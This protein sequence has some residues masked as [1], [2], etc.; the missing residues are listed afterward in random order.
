MKVTR[1]EWIGWGL[2]AGAVAAAGGWRSAAFAN[3]APTGAPHMTVIPSTGEQLPCVG[4]GTVDYRGGLSS[5][6]MDTLRET[7]A[8][9]HR[10]GGRVLDTSPNYGNS[11]EVLGHLLS[12]I[13]IRDAMWIATKVDQADQAGGERRMQGSFERLG[14]GIE[15]MQ[16]HNLVGA[17]VQLET[18]KAW[19]ADGRF[20]YIGITTHRV[21]QQD[22]IMRYMREHDLDFVQVN[23]SV[24]DRAAADR[25][26]PLAQDRGVAVLVNRPFGD[27][28]LFRTVRGLPL[29]DWAADIDA[30]S[31][32]Q[33]LLKYIIGHPAATIPIPGTTKPQHAEDNAGAMYGRLPDAALRGE[34]ERYFDGLRR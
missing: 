29:P 6:G 21:E 23:Y 19:K 16:V 13:G 11:E 33:V 3:P 31:W 4:L 7:L 10:L 20:R 24:V 22:E 32:G 25:L 8:T 26:L 1:R 17:D 5:A 27:G 9:F 12:D 18:L 28:D 30:Q 14:G 15:L 34:M 2:G